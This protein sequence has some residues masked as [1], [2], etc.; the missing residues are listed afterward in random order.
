MTANS[1]TEINFPGFVQELMKKMKTILIAALLFLFAGTL[2]SIIATPLYRSVI[3]IY[4]TADE[5]TVNNTLNEIQGVASAFG[6]NLGDTGG[7]TA[8]YI[9]DVIKS[10]RISKKIVQNTWNTEKYQSPVS[11]I[12]FW[13]IDD[14]T[15]ILRR[16]KKW[17]MSFLPKGKG[18]PSRKFTAAAIKELDSRVSVQEEDSGLIVLSVLMEEPQLA[19][20]IAQFYGEFIKKYIAE[21][22]EIQSRKNR[23]FL[24]ERLDSAKQE[25][26]ESEEKLTEFRKQHTMALEPPDT[27]LERG[28]LMRNV[29]V[30][31]EVY[32]TLR[33]QYELARIEE[34]KE[35][36]IINILDHP[37]PA[38]D[39]DSPKRLLIII[40]SL[41]AG[42][43]VGVI[44]A[45]WNIS[46]PVNGL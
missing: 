17:F 3:S 20:D 46:A 42:A 37:E 29:T 7:Q 31:Q 1:T 2:Y 25:L 24:E 12:H 22:L 40:G 4:P 14:N 41:I 23:Q 15:K 39:I 18:D 10:R 30:N 21:E 27:Q 36:P 35:L 45:T 13:E 26:L 5:N 11:L 8:F 33:Q 34:L 32:I 43:V 28:R 19:S 16:I 38:A 44:F 9:P 6:F